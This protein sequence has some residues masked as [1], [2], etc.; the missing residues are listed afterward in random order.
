MC[1]TETGPGVP[2]HGGGFRCACGCCGCGGGHGVRRFYSRAEQLE[3]LENYL[4]QLKREIGGVE[5]HLR[6]LKK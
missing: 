3:C 4:D 5:E 6:E 1:Q 2:R